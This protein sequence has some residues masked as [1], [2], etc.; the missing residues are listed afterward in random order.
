MQE[1]QNWIY[2]KS[3]LVDNPVTP[4]ATSIEDVYKLVDP[5][6]DD[7]PIIDISLKML[8]PINVI[9]N[10]REQNSQNKYWQATYS[11]TNTVAH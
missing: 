7:Y 3:E 9:N 1:S 10:R 4:T 11:K 5:L 6:V 2:K 8:V